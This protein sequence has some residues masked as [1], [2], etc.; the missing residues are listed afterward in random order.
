M[1]FLFTPLLPGQKRS[2]KCHF[3]SPSPTETK[4]EVSNVISILGI[5]KMYQMSLLFNLQDK[6]VISNVI[7]TLKPTHQQKRNLICNPIPPTLPTG[8]KRSSNVLIIKCLNILS[9]KACLM[10]HVK[11]SNFVFILQVRMK[12]IF[13]FVF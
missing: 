12:E 10:K 1:S 5:K 2:M 9:Y 3:Y 13:M 6:K 11:L 8:R 4:N 7:S